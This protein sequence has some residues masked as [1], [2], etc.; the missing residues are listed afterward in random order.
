MTY[1]YPDEGGHFGEYGGRYVPE[2]LMESVLELN[3][4]YKKY[5]DDSAFKKRTRLLLRRVCWS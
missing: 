1:N 4:A 2:V 5:Q 3:D